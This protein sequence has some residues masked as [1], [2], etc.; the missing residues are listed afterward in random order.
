MV[1]G[2]RPGEVESKPVR[3]VLPHDRRER[4][5][6]R[7]ER[8]APDEKERVEHGHTGRGE[9]GSGK[10]FFARWLGEVPEVDR[11]GRQLKT[12][13]EGKLGERFAQP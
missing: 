12:D 6:E 2:P 1:R 8:A 13:S 10:T 3:F 9:Y 11:T 4:L 7:F 5:L